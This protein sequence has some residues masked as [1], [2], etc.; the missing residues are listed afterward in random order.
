MV[1][2]EFLQEQ[3][4]RL[5]AEFKKKCGIDPFE[6]WSKVLTPKDITEAMSHVFA[7]FEEDM[8]EIALLGILVTYDTVKSLFPRE[9]FDEF[10]KHLEKEKEEK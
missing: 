2:K 1:F 3:D 4:D 9:E 7:V 8:P 5:T 6:E 10:V